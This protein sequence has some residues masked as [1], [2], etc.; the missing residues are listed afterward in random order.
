MPVC[1]RESLVLLP[2]GGER[3]GG[4]DQKAAR[5]E[6]KKSPT[7]LFYMKG[8]SRK[9]FPFIEKENSACRLWTLEADRIRESAG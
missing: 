9:D 2:P 4:A 3:R 6:R 1:L 5:P 7:E 8:R